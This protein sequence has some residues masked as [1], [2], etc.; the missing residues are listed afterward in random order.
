MPK[1]IIQIPCLNE[2]E[3][4]PIALAA[5]PR[6]VDGF[7]E[8]EWLVV[9]D[10][11]TDGTVRV[12]TENGVDHI[13]SL[14]HNQGLAKA[15]MAGIETA[16]K[17]GADVIVNT[18]ADNQYDASCIPDLVRPILEKRAQIVVGAR[19]ISEIEHFSPIKKIL[20][21]FGSWTV[22]LASDTSVADAPSGFRAIHRDAAMQLNVF[23]R[24]TYT[25]ETIIQAGRKDIPITSVPIRVNGDLRPSRLVK[26]I[27]SYI[28]RSL[29]TIVRIFIVYSP[30]RF[31]TTCAA[32]IAVPGVLMI[33]RFLYKYMIGEG[34]GNIQSLV[35]S[36]ALIALA[37]IVAMSGVLAELIAVN[38]QLLEEI[39]IRQLQQE[40]NNRAATHSI[41]SRS[42]A[43]EEN[44][45]SQRQ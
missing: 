44:K 30:L 8:V 28:R 7:D 24:Y 29:V 18:D 33:A 43:D 14:T 34:S 13:V 31:F 17:L 1:L 36:S 3:T 5:L 27:P 20:Q 22:K 2:E 37:G 6:Q 23:N 26:S 25:L 16:L 32:I 10:G 42:E 15:F 12:A 45:R 40:M 19:P 39:R 35:L 11:S 21:R 9:D 41:W 38:R 4:L